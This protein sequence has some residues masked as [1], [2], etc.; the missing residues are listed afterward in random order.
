M[1]TIKGLR[2]PTEDK[3][4][5]EEPEVEPEPAPEPAP[6][7]EELEPEEAAPAI[8]GLRAPAGLRSS[9]PGEIVAAGGKTALGS[10]TRFSG[11]LPGAKIGFELGSRFG[12][13]GMLVGTTLGIAGGYFAGDMAADEL[14]RQGFAVT[15][16]Y[17]LPPDQRSAGVIGEALG[18][19][20]TLGGQVMALGRMSAR[21]PDS[22]VG[23]ALNGI[24]DMARD[25][26]LRFLAAE[27]AALT[28]SAAAEGVFEEARPGRP[29]ERMGVG[30]AVGA[31]N[32]ARLAII[33]GNKVFAIGKSLIQRMSYS[34]RQ[35]RAGQLL[36]QFLGSTEDPAVLMRALAETD[37]I[38]RTIPGF[39][40]TAAQTTGDLR[41]SQLEGELAELDRKFFADVA[42]R[43]DDSLEAISN[44]I[45]LLRGTGDPKALQG[46]AE[47]RL[48][49]YNMAFERLLGHAQREAVEAAVDVGQ[50]ATVAERAA[51]SVQVTEIYQ[52]ALTR[53]RDVEKVLWTEAL[54]DAGAPAVWSK[55]KRTYAGLRGELAAADVLPKFI[56]DQINVVATA[57]T[58]L[59]RVE[60]GF[61]KLPDGS[62]ISAAMIREA[63]KR[64]SVGEL[65]RFRSGLLA[66]A[67]GMARSTDEL[68]D[69]QARQLGLMAE[70]VL[71]DMVRAG[72]ATKTTAREGVRRGV[73][74]R[75]GATETAFDVARE[76]TAQLNRA[77]GKSFVGAAQQQGAYGLRVPP[78]TLLKRA[79]AT[80][81]EVATLQ[82]RELQEAADF[83]P[84]RTLGNP[85]LLADANVDATLMMDLQARLMRIMAGRA[86]D[87]VLDK[88][89]GEQVLKVSLSKA[90][91]FLGEAGGLLEDFP[92][93]A[94]SLEAAVQT[95]G[96]LQA[97]ARRLKGLSRHLES[98]SPIARA[99]GVESPAD[100][101]RGALTN[102]KPIERLTEMITLA[103]G[104]GEDGAA[105]LRAAI[106]D[107]VIRAAET[108]DK[109]LSLQ[110]MVATLMDPIAPG[111]PSLRQ[112]ME[113][114]GLLPPEA[115]KRLDELLDAATRVMVATEARAVGEGVLD[116]THPIEALLVRGMGSEL[117]R[118]GLRLLQ[119][120]SGGGSGGPTLI[121]AFQAARAANAFVSR[122]P[123]EAVKKILIEAVSGEPLQTAGAIRRGLAKA[124]IGDVP[125]TQ[126]PW[127]LLEALVETGGTD[128]EKLQRY[129]LLHA[130]AWQAGYLG[131]EDQFEGVVPPPAAESVAIR[132]LRPA[133][134]VSETTPPA[135]EEAP[136]PT[137]EAEVP[138]QGEGEPETPIESD[139]E[140]ELA[141]RTSTGEINFAIL[142]ESVTEVETVGSGMLTAAVEQVESGGDPDAV[143]SAG[144]LG[145]M[146]VMPDTLT[147]P[148]FGVAPARPGPDGKIS[149]EEMRRVGRDFLMAML[150]RYAGNLD[151]ALVAYNWGPGNADSWVQ[152]GADVSQLPEETQSYIKKVRKELRT[153]GGTAPPKPRRRPTG[154]AVIR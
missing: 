19:G 60:K 138:I 65:V 103:K 69:R 45:A 66:R 105:G 141:I 5:L 7:T 142:S 147:N 11:I 23:R 151:H 52:R 39:R 134:S 106:M 13:I 75:L 86:V 17:S 46:I 31:A 58:L 72:A 59:K 8:P 25:Q 120:G 115:A 51:L 32:P 152:Q 54:P 133:G 10:A 49:R 146:Q 57:V 137:T 111:L 145:S 124:G 108:P 78:E 122:L 93:V 81:D 154:G 95:E 131:P 91:K 94:R 53:A 88:E 96:T 82:L 35:T 100:A 41:L 38:A 139:G 73:G 6:E 116:A 2:S 77:F 26:P 70:A 98:D 107:H 76:Y 20:A 21:L 129:Y 84:A 97:W 55:V 44:S 61:T 127:S 144:A 143:S 150:Q 1:A 28:Q 56:E 24:L 63:K 29:L 117:G 101:V 34:G 123:S 149:A 83:L 132:G 36:T 113:T 99:L 119:A 9:S 121:V 92:E 90:K 71:D 126:R 16:P 125:P 112:V 110:R 104:A 48:A 87:V 128:A 74:G 68:A 40:G 18:A 153:K 47:L 4:E 22:L 114:S 3:P 118:R 140:S 62:K 43:A 85:A 30:M 64:T 67:R 33:T 130:Y 135:P 27:T 109:S 89:T 15:D 136:A 80:G 148:G 102:P 14:E 42:Q 79:F 12:P 50:G 37:Q